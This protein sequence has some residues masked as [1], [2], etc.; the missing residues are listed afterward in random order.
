MVPFAEVVLLTAMEYYRDDSHGDQGTMLMQ[1][2]VGEGDSEEERCQ[3]CW[4][5]E[6]KTL[7]DNPFELLPIMFNVKICS[8]REERVALPGVVRLHCLFCNG[9]NVLL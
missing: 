9:C 5:P 7:G 1:L 2:N 6:L 3:K 8:F 4:I